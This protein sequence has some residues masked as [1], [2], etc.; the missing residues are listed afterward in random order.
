V[1]RF[2]AMPELKFLLHCNTHVLSQMQLPNVKNI[3]Y[4]IFPIFSPCFKEILDHTCGS[5]FVGDISSSNF[6]FLVVNQ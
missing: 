3:N 1:V 5:S 2:L 4:H 6:N